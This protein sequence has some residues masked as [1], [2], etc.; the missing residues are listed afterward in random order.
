MYGVSGR[1]TEERIRVLVDAK[2]PSAELEAFRSTGPSSR[3]P[4]PGRNN[5]LPVLPSEPSKELHFCSKKDAY[6]DPCPEGVSRDIVRMYNK[7][8]VST[9]LIWHTTEIEGTSWVR[10]GNVEGEPYGSLSILSASLGTVVETMRIGAASD[11]AHAKCLAKLLECVNEGHW[12]VIIEQSTPSHSLYRELGRVLATLLPDAIKHPQRE[13]FR[14]WVVLE[15]GAAEKVNLNKHVD[16]VFPRIFLQNALMSSKSS[17]SGRRRKI[18]RMLTTD[19]YGHPEFPDTLVNQVQKHCTR[20]ASGRDSDSESDDD[21]L[22]QVHCPLGPGANFV[23]AH[24]LA[25]SSTLYGE[26]FAPV[27]PHMLTDGANL[28]KN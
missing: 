26:A 18:V 10:R 5:V 20:I 1:F 7:S 27:P 14:L 22:D 13:L 9:P 4:S 2:W 19:P 24:E 15:T 28:I 12:L 8:H 21:Q 23:R 25:S 17:R 6:A 3:P 16:P 11:G